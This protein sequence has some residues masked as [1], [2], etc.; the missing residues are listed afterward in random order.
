MVYTIEQKQQIRGPVFDKVNSLIYKEPNDVV[1]GELLVLLGINMDECIFHEKRKQILVLGP[2]SGKKSA[3][4]KCARDLGITREMLRFYDDYDKLSHYDI[5]CLKNNCSYSDVICGP[6]PH[7]M[8]GIGN[9]SS[10]LSAIDKHPDCYPK[11]QKAISGGELKITLDNFP[12]LLKNT[13]LYHEMIDKQL[14]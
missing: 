9:S 6:V 4:I 8:K 1:F 10:L 12:D 5:S 3:F 7:K 11:V 13:N 14:R 2:L